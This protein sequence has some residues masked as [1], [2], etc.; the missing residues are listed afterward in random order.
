MPP[1][2]G[3]P[4]AESVE[5]LAAGGLRGYGVDDYVQ[6]ALHREDESGDVVEG[7]VDAVRVGERI[8]AID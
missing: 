7:E 3:G 1:W 2:H 4:S 8:D 5:E 6:E